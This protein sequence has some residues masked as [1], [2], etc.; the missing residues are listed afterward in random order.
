MFDQPSSG[1]HNS[2]TRLF[3]SDKG[4]RVHQVDSEMIDQ[5][6]WKQLKRITIPMFSGDKKTYKNWRAAFMACVDQAQATAEYK[7]LYTVTTISCWGGL[8]GYRK[9]RSFCNSISNCK[10][11]IR[12]KVWRSATSNSVVSR[13]NR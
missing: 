3:A 11:E 7:L 4:E 8:E 13:R 9:F 10:G 5:D 6:L 1:M 2:E 12:L